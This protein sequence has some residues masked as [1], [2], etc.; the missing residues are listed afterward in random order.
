LDDFPACDD[1]RI[2]IHTAQERARDAIEAAQRRQEQY[3]NQKRRPITFNVDDQVLLKS[4][5]FR[6]PAASTEAT[7]KIGPRY[8]GPFKIIRQIGPVT[9]ELDLPPTM[10]IHPRFHV[11]KLKPYLDPT[12]IEGRPHWELPPPD[13]IDGQD[14]YGV[15]YIVDKRRRHRRTEYLVHWKGYPSYDR[16][17][18]PEENLSNAQDA[19]LGFEN[20]R[21]QEIATVLEEKNVTGVPSKSHRSDGAAYLW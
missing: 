7:R 13:V 1:I 18:E 17:W 15:E 11:S 19:V 14:E 8:L 16:T 12:E 21:N 6:D 9:Y 2:K 5:S 20:R 3:A 4:D 10:K